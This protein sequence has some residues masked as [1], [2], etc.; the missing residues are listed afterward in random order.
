M[1]A[2]AVK[3]D[4]SAKWLEE[5]E[6]TA[7]NRLG[8]ANIAVKEK[9]QKAIEDFSLLGIP[10]KKV[11]DYK[12]T[13]IRLYLNE[14]FNLKA[15]TPRLKASDIRHLFIGGHATI[16]MINGRFVKELSSLKNLPKEVTIKNLFTALK[17]SDSIAGVTFSEKAE[18][19]INPLL[20]LNSALSQD[21]IFISVPEGY[22]CK[23]PIHMLNISTGVNKT[24]Y[25]PRNVVKVAEGAS[26]TLIESYHSVNL[27]E[28]VF[29]NSVTEIIVEK[30]ATLNNY[31]LQEEDAN[32]RQNNVHNAS[33]GETGRFNSTVVCLN[34]GMVRNDLNISINGEHSEIH[35]HGLFIVKDSHHTD[36]HTLVEH[37]VPNCFSNELYKGIICD[38]GTGVFNGKIYVK[39]DAQKT[40]AYQSNKNILMGDKATINTKPQLEIYAD[41]VKCSHG[42]TTGRL[43]EDALFYLE[44]R[45]L[46]ENLARKVLLGAFAKEISDTIKDKAFREFIE[47]R[48][49]A[50]IVQ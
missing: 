23:G 47:E 39:Q 49:E 26:L 40:N 6:Q 11:E 13:N 27:T 45:G 9:Q 14:D 22:D 48:I 10:D 33:V 46:D 19:E 29:T 31:V 38:G 37:N 42:T 12:Y 41:D 44:T 24:L 7:A 34:G 2:V 36:N 16:V 3:K 18:R 4:T 8:A 20:L 43:D 25:N 32:A 50:H 1:S 15:S 28:K 21:G 30:Q 17:E 5:F 35:M